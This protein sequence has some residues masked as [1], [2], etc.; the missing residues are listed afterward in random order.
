MSK[1]LY[2]PV[3]GKAEELEFLSIQWHWCGKGKHALL[4]WNDCSEV[5]RSVQISRQAA[6]LLIKYGMNHGS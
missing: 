5:V 3:K 4:E 1:L 6:E 2:K